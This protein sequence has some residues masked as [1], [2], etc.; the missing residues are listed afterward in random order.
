M[1]PYQTFTQL[2]FTWLKAPP[3]HAAKIV[4]DYLNKPG[5][6]SR[7]DKSGCVLPAYSLVTLPELALPY[8]DAPSPSAPHTFVLW[9]PKNAPATAAC[10]R[11]RSGPPFE[12]RNHA[13]LRCI[14]V[15]IS[16]RSL[17]Y[18]SCS[19][20]Y[21]EGDASRSLAAL[22]EERGWVFE[23]YG[24]PQQFENPEYYKRR[25]I[26][27]RLNREIITAYMKRLG[28][29]ISDDM[30]W[31]TEKA[32]FRIAEVDR[33][34][35]TAEQAS[36]QYRERLKRQSEERGQS[37][38]IVAS[39]TSSTESAPLVTLEQFFRGGSE[40]IALNLGNKHPG[41]TVFFSVLK[42]VRGLPN[43][44]DV[45]V[46]LTEGDLDDPS[47][48]MSSERIY[49]AS[50]MRKEEL[51]NL[52]EVLCPDEIEDTDKKE[53]PGRAEPLRDGYKVYSLWWD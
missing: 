21:A 16:D 40:A 6:W 42:S 50:S 28:A 7:R 52:V 14:G 49:V 5:A 18:P 9:E 46:E 25:L 2:V 11:A 8:V 38:P 12:L 4:L 47:A 43:V 10:M 35:L 39:P 48:Q 1:N 3:D 32:V 17:P 27:D 34:K 44:Q 22:K 37:A 19:F 23:A 31:Q 26:E 15:N 20:Q 13:S 51:E 30:F 24:P 45:L 33:P 36:I 41:N 53:L 29:N